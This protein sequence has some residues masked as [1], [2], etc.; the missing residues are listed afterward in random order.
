MISLA[1]RPV[2]EAY[3]RTEWTLSSIREAL[4]EA[5]VV[6]SISTSSIGRILSR[7]DLKPHRYRMWVHSPDPEFARKV[8]DPDARQ[9]L[10][11]CAR[12]KLTT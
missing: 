7:V 10:T 5:E 9:K 4:F 2:P 1:C 6:E 8:R 3:C 12:Q 11:T